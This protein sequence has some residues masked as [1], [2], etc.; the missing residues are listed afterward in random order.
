[1]S[2]RKRSVFHEHLE[3]DA[4]CVWWDGSALDE[5]PS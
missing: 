4:R 2:S 1:M 3:P 5:W